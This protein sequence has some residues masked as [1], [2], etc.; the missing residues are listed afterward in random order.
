MKKF[1]NVALVTDSMTQFGGADRVL[2]S[3]IK[4][5]PN[6]KV[7]TSFFDPGAYPESFKKYK[8]TTFLDRNNHF[9]KLLTGISRQLNFL[10][11]YFFE[12]FNLEGYD[13]VISFTAGP[14]K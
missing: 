6:A 12:K 9:S 11:P 14:A 3:L 2:E 13:L 4:V 5:F 7:F 8:I 1:R 10:H